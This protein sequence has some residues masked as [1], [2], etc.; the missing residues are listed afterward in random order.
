MIP[1]IVDAYSV[2]GRTRVLYALALV[3]VL[4]NCR[5]GLRKAMDE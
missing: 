3:S 5:F 2:C 1:Y 4:V